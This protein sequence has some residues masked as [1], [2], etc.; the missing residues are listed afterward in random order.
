MK[1]L[2]AYAGDIMLD[3]SGIDCVQVAI[4]IVPL[5]FDSFVEKHFLLI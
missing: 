3:Y 5:N 1:G 4:V 2:L